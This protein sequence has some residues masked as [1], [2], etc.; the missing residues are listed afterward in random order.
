M[1]IENWEASDDSVRHM[2][3]KHGV[4]WDEVGEVF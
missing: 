4:T 3:R 1:R 2:R